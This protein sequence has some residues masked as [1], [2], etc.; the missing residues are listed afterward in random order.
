MDWERAV[1]EPNEVPCSTR[2]IF[3]SGK[4][5]RYMKASTAHR[6]TEGAT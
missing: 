2:N 5:V 1:R 3:V 6:C 4:M